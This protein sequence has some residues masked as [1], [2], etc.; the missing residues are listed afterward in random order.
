MTMNSAY[1]RKPHRRNDGVS[2]WRAVIGIIV[3]FTLVILAAW[4]FTKKVEGAKRTSPYPS[5]DSL[6]PTYL[7]DGQDVIRWYVFTDPDS[8]VQYLVN[9]RG[10]CTPR[11]E[12]PIREMGG[13]SNG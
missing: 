5:H 13:I 1:Y 10:G 9:D 11:L 7:Y 12:K 8:G 2:A 3:V 6:G 4:W